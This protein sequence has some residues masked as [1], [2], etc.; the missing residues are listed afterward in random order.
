MRSYHEGC[1]TPHLAACATRCQKSASARIAPSRPPTVRPWASTTAFMAPALVALMPSISNRGS[2]RRRS[3]TP[4]VKAP[5]APPPCSARLATLVSAIAVAAYRRRAGP[6]VGAKPCGVEERCAASAAPPMRRRPGLGRLVDRASAFGPILEGAEIVDAVVAHLLEYLAA[7][8][9][10]SARRAIDD[11]GLVLGEILVV[12]GRLGIGAEF[13]HAARDVHGAGDLAALF[14]FRSIAHVDHQRVALGDHLARLLRR[15][16]RHRGVGR[17]HHLLDARRHGHLLYP[18]FTTL[19]SRDASQPRDCSQDITPRGAGGVS[20]SKAPGGASPRVNAPTVSPGM[21]AQAVS[22]VIAASGSSPGSWPQARCASQC[23]RAAISIA[24][25][26][27]G[28]TSC[29]HLLCASAW[30]KTA[31]W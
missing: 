4:Q 21:R 28:S 16:P 3:R 14:H 27:A 22:R 18:G 29:A 13:Q 5:W 20:K 25:L 30:P 6:P 1:K 10:A 9:R 2:F 23:H 11:H 19:R 8:G 12:V 7:Q 17:F 26:L 15:D 31:R 24:A